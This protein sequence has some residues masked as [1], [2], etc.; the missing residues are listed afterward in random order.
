MSEPM[1]NRFMIA[2]P[3]ATAEKLCE[4]LAAAGIAH[5]AVLHTGEA[6]LSALGS[7]VALLLTVWKLEDMTGMELAERAGED[8]GVLMICPRDEEMG[9]A[10]HG[11]VLLLRNP[12]SPD[13]LVQAVRAMFFCGERMS[14]MRA[15]VEKLERTLED[16]KIIERAKGRL[17][18]ALKLS[19]SEAHHCMQKKSM[20]SGRRIADVA[21]EILE[22][23]DVSAF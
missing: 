16:R 1:S 2:A 23:K 12:V 13:A 14:R 8:V 11:N 5:G 7:G 19:E 6:A 4:I 17:M 3:E 18:D 15:K 20:D 9:E 10:K 21:R 22:M